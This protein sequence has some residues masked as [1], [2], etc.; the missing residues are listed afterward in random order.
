MQT[1]IHLLGDGTLDF[2]DDAVS[3]RR[4]RVTIQ[5]DDKKYEACKRPAEAPSPPLASADGLKL[6]GGLSFARNHLRGRSRLNQGNMS[7]LVW[8]S[9]APWQPTRREGWRQTGGKRRRFISV[10]V[11][12]LASDDV[13]EGVRRAR[14]LRLA[15]DP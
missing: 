4:G 1:G 5:A 7:G 3:S 6:W 2:A 11:L 14:T 8:L 15:R 10:H 9:R 13:T 12:L